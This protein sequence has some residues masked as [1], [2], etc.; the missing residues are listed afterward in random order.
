MRRIKI[1]SAF[2][3]VAL[4]LSAGVG[5]A[6][7]QNLLTAQPLV[8]EIVKPLERISA[9]RPGLPSPQ[10]DLSGDRCGNVNSD[11]LSSSNPLVGWQPYSD[12]DY[13]FT[14]EYPARWMVK[15]NIF[16][17]EPLPDPDAILKRLTFT[18]AEGIIDLDIWLS[19][20]RDL[21]D[22]LE[23][24]GQTRYKLPITHPNAMVGGRPAVVFLQ[25]GVAVDMM[26]TFFT[27]GD[28]V[29][30]VWYTI[31]HNEAGLQAYKHMLDTFVLPKGKAI[32]AQLP[33][34]VEGEARLAADNS[35]VVNP[36][37]SSCCG[38]SSPG[39]PFPCCNNKGNCTGWV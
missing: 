13:E 4:T 3:L 7:A 5:M 23:W 18:G 11:P 17:P 35:G 14:L 38:Y 26:A 15:K 29:Y 31:T 6:W 24:Y 1:F 2:V 20:G 30:R 8:A 16:Q 36:L 28:Y 34:G 21:S 39:N 33:E 19:H 37:V 27:D 32:V 22:W 10:G 25:K 9:F 12:P